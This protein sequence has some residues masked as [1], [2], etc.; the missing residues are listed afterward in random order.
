MITTVSAVIAT[1]NRVDELVE[2]LQ[3]LSR[4]TMAPAEVLVV[5]DAST[6]GTSAVVRHDFPRVRLIRLPRNM[7]LIHA[8]NIG[9]VN[10]T[11]GYV[12]SLDDDSWFESQDGLARALAFA[13]SH[14]DVGAVALNVE[15]RDGLVYYP[16]DAAP[17]AVAHYTGCGHLLRRRAV[18][19]AGLYIDAFFRQ[20][21]EK[22]R[23]LRLMD[24]GWRIT[25]L[26]EV[27]VHHHKS[28][29]GRSGATA[30]YYDQRNDLI[31]E[32]ARCPVG[33]LPQ[34]FLRTWAG[35]TWKNLRFGP[36]T[37][38]LKVLLALPRIARIGLRHREPVKVEVYRR[39]VELARERQPGKIGFADAGAPPLHPAKG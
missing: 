2:G 21:E 7:G 16:R 23:G 4:Q 24:A 35:H 34:R 33:L 28:E 1:R 38:D 13:E 6:D 15:T 10:T 27:V 37:T 11:G 26:P 39:W 3:R 18:E 32:I 8:R 5:D 31:R 17:F 14:D 9:F 12:L 30:R 36:R 20:G 22:D 29:K 25:A 19:D